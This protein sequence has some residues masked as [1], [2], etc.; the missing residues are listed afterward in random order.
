MYGGAFGNKQ[1]SVFPNLEVKPRPLLYPPLQTLRHN[2]N[3]SPPSFPRPPGGAQVLA[4]G[5]SRC[6][7]ARLQR[8]DRPAAGPAGDVPPVPG[9]RD[10]ESAEAQCLVS[11]PAG[12]Q[13]AVWPRVTPT[14]HSILTRSSF[15][16]TFH[17]LALVLFYFS[18]L[19]HQPF[20]YHINILF[21]WFYFDFTGSMFETKTS[22]KF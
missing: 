14:T 1:D 10:T 7:L 5:A 15:S 21:S 8:S 19:S 16:S 9:P 13:A 4:A 18:F 12:L 20:I 3:H 22:I 11:G 2:C 6:L 17:F